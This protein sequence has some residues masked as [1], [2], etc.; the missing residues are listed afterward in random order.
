MIVLDGIGLVIDTELCVLVFFVVFL[1]LR[2]RGGE[3]RAT[4][5]EGRGGWTDADPS[6]QQ[7]EEQAQL[8]I[9]PFRLDNVFRVCTFYMNYSCS[10]QKQNWDFVRALTKN[11]S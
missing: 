7:W 2:Y 10:M 9:S 11:K 4:E 6:I 5:L 3:G 8:I 1:C